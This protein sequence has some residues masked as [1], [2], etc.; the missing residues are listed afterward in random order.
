[1]IPVFETLENVYIDVNV[2]TKLCVCVLS[3]SVVSDSLQ[4]NG[5]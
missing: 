4:S 2:N 5:L 3:R 1:M